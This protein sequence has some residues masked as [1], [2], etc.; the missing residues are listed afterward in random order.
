MSLI[1]LGWKK[2]QE[3]W[4]NECKINGYEL[5]R[6]ITEYPSSYR[7]MTQERELL[8]TVSG[9]FRFHAHQRSD[10]PCVGDWISFQRYDE[11]KGMIHSIFPRFSQFSRK[12]A[13]TGLEEQNVASNVDFVFLVS[14]LNQDFN[15][16]RIERYLVLAWESGSNPVIVLNK[17]DLCPDVHEKV[18]QVEGIACGV[19]IHVISAMSH[20]GIQELSP[21]VSA[22]NTVALLG[23]SG[24][25][26]STLVNALLGTDRQSTQGSREKDGKGRHT[27]TNRELI[28][29]PQGGAI[30]DTP[31]MREIQLGSIVS[32]IDD[33]F[34]DIIDLAQ[35]CHFIDC[36]HRKETGCAVQ[37]AIEE[38]VLSSERLHS[39]RKLQRE[40]DYMDRKVD[41][42]LQLAEKNRTKK[43]QK[44]YNHHFKRR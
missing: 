2:Q 9:K 29:L 39:Y 35:S 23:S 4:E 27:T 12:E 42:D 8:G 5:G 20:Q 24:V 26:K 14:A 6:I 25:G 3:A 10:Y 18:H 38:G 15:L 17:G 37:Q 16:R 19:P 21:Y 44:A 40:L 41:K 33:A 34:M 30:I 13:G 36:T 43:Q 7:I 32:G 31:G 28:A 11:D 22:G 1:Q